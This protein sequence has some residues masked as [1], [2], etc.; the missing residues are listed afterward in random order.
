MI[1]PTDGESHESIL[2]TL[3]RYR[4]RDIAWRTGRTFGF[5]YDPGEEAEAIG[6]QAYAMYLTEN[7]LDGI[8]PVS[9]LTETNEILGGRVK[10]LHPSIFAGLLARRDRPDH[11]EQLADAG[12]EQIDIVVVN[13]YPFAQTVR[14]AGTTLD[15][16]LEQ[17]DIGG[18][19]LLR[20]AAKNFPGVAAVSSPTS[21][22]IAA[23][24]GKCWLSQ[25]RF[26]GRPYSAGAVT[27]A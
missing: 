1:L 13:L 23:T 15:Q 19:A 11:L 22:S 17:I 5:V 26:T 20:A 10:T 9:D 21:A 4:E 27:S 16:A 12:I 3:E 2:A 6:K 25:Y 7:G 14:D 24:F 18:V 8:R